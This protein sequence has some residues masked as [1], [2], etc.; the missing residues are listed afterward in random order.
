MKDTNHVVMSF[1]LVPHDSHAS[2]Y[3]KA[4]V[5]FM[6]DGSAVLRSYQTNVCSIDANGAFHRYWDDYSATTMRHIH[7]FALI[8]GGFVSGGKSWWTA[9]PVET[10]SDAI[11]YARP[12]KPRKYTANYPMGFNAGRLYW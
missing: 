8:Y 4:H 1:E 6:S 9:L 7:T 3:G 2:Y 10:E 12:D 11:Y 5:M